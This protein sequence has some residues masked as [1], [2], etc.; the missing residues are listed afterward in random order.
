MTT[1]TITDM[2]FCL[3]KDGKAHAGRVGELMRLCGTE[4]WKP[5]GT[6]GVPCQKCLDAAAHLATA[7]VIDPLAEL[8]AMTA[9]R[10][11]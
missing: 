11:A 1:T 9:R 3:G 8:K 5:A 6:H 2:D 7:P 10:T 4:A